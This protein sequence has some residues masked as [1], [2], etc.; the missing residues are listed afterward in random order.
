MDGANFD[1]KEDWAFDTYAEGLLEVAK[2]MPDRKFTFIHRQHFAAAEEISKKFKPLLEQEN[3]D[4]IFSF[5]YAKAHVFSAM[6]Q[7]YH[8]SFVEEIGDL[9]TIWT[10]RNDDNYY[11]RW[12]APDFVRTFIKNMPYEVSQGLYYGSDQ[13]VWGREFLEKVPPYDSRQIEIEKH[14]YHWM[15]WGR[16]SFDPNLPNKRILDILENR[17]DEVDATALFTAWQ[18]ASMVY[19]ITTG[20]SMVY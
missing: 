14:W 2:E 9:K 13:W 3:I 10:L 16:L 7:P 8:E 11:F 18:N 20:F 19:P 1:A 12:G 15:L 6:E 17:F 4:F 5:K